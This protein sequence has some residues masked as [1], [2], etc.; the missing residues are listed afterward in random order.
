LP[1]F[2]EKVAELLNT[3]IL[4]DHGYAELYLQGKWVM[5]TPTLD[6]E[7]C[8][9]NQIIPVEFDGINDA[10]FHSH[11]QDGKF[12]IEYISD[13]GPYGDVPLNEIR[14]WLLAVLK[15]E[16]ERMILGEE[17]L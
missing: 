3:N 8:Q 7:M 6:L 14:E 13:R 2:P 1:S 16:G 12:H 9:K 17:P 5:A 4:P 10:K 11:T 15:P